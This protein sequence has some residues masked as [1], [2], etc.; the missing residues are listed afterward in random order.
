MKFDDM[1][2][3]YGDKT[4]SAKHGSK[5]RAQPVSHFINDSV[6][7]VPLTDK[8]LEL[9]LIQYTVM[10]EF[11]EKNNLELRYTRLFDS[12]KRQAGALV[13]WYKRWH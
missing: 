10:K 9:V 4:Y 11:I 6:V 3:M 1:H 8:Q 12:K 7:R 5:K 2:L 13:D